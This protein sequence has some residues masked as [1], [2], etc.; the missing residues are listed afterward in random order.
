[1]P[2][3]CVGK[4]DFRIIKTVIFHVKTYSTLFKLAD[5]YTLFIDIFLVESILKFKHRIPVLIHQKK[6]AHFRSERFYL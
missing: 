2:D 4:S 6:E 3:F 1:M 5:F